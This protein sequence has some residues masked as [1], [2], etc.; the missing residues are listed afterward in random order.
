MFSDLIVGY[1]FLGG[2]GGGFLL[3]LCALEY[4][5]T[6]RNFLARLAFP[7]GF[8]ELAWLI[9]AAVIA[10]SIAFLVADLGVSDRFF[11]VITMPTASPLTVGAYSLTLAFGIALTFAYLSHT[12]EGYASTIPVQKL[13]GVPRMLGRSN[14]FVYGM[15]ILEALGSI[16]GIIIMLYT[17]LMLSAM[18]SVVAWGTPL[19]PCLFVLS[20]LSCGIALIFIAAAFTESRQ[21]FFQSLA[22]FTTFDT[23]LIVLEALCLAAYIAWCFYGSYTREAG[24]ALLKGAL[25][26][27]MW[28]TLALCGLCAPVFLERLIT[29]QNY[30]NQLLWIA[31]GILVGGF[32]LRYCI[33]ALAVLDPSIVYSV[34]LPAA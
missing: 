14:R 7:L 13:K 9:C 32:A 33:V 8:F 31:G 1:L 16:A 21:T 20:S 4:A 2:A 22:R 27:W 5:N 26:P 29:R 12:S 19:V 3:L 34:A 30:R 10:T 18:P 24:D 17:G 28:G 15:Y 23:I 6:S 11:L 25:A